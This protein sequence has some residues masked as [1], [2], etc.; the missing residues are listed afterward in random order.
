MLPIVPRYRQTLVVPQNECIIVL[1]YSWGGGSQDSYM[2]AASSV[3]LKH[4]FYELHEESY[5]I[6]EKVKEDYFIFHVT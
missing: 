2:L 1:S 3:N 6:S 5:T 4:E